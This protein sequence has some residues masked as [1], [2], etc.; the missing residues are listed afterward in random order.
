MT[1]VRPRKADSSGAGAGLVEMP[2]SASPRGSVSKT[3]LG[4]SWMASRTVGPALPPPAMN[5]AS[6]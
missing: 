2:R 3:L 1:G 6:R 5:G 4:S